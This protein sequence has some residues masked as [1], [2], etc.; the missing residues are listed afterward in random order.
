MR[1]KSNLYPADYEVCAT[2]ADIK[3]NDGSYDFI[4]SNVRD[5]SLLTGKNLNYLEGDANGVAV[6]V[7]Y[8]EGQD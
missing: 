5:F 7:W 8:Y 4:A 1:T 2:G 3:N 6:K